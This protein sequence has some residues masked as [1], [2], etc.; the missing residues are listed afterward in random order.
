MKHIKEFKP[1]PKKII[2]E[3]MIE[4]ANSRKNSK[5]T[6]SEFNTLNKLFNYRSIHN[7]AI[8]IELKSK[9][10]IFINK[11][12]D[13]WYIIND[14]AINDQ[15]INYYIADQFDEVINYLKNI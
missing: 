7:S 6:D 4:F 1:M 12:E 10:Y 5:F 3:D 8:R 9:C 11:Y 14:Q 2:F 15:A 13:E